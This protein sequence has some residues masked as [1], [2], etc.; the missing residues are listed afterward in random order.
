MGHL[1]NLVSHFIIILQLFNLDLLFLLFPSLSN[2]VN[3]K[4]NTASTSPD[5]S[6]CYRYTNQGDLLIGIGTIMPR[7]FRGFFR[8]VKA[9]HQSH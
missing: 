5:P 9:T 6:R 4:H 3:T 7:V 2:Y 1:G 8:A